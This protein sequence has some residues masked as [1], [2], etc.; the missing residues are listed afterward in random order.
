M[1]R[2]KLIDEETGYSRKQFAE[3]E[4]LLFRLPT[5]PQKETDE[6]DEIDETKKA[7]SKENGQTKAQEKP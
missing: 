3:S 5:N 6:T 1:S 4:D 7:N 2:T